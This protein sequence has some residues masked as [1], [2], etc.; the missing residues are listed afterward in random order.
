MKKISNKNSANGYCPLDQNK[1]IPNSNIP[2]FSFSN[3]T[4]IFNIVSPPNNQILC[5]NNSVG[6]FENT[7]INSSFLSDSNISSAS[8][9]QVLQY[10]NGKWIN[11]T[12]N[13]TSTLSGDSDVSLNNLSNGQVL[14]FNV[15]KWINTT[16]TKGSTT[17]SSDSD[18]SL[19]GLSNGQLLQ[20]NSSSS[21]WINISPTY[22]SSCSINACTDVVVSSLT[23][24]NIIRWNGSNWDNAADLTNAETNIATYKFQLEF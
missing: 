20:Y 16:L 22:I 23:N 15:S 21:K 10:S 9:N 19:S 6:L 24:K 17:L 4:N 18:V 11:A 8:S 12:L 5:Y 7:L 1:L 13:F 2:Q 14:Q 3:L